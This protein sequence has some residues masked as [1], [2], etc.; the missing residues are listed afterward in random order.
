MK[1][2]SKLLVG[3]L[4]IAMLSTVLADAH[5]NKKVTRNKEENEQNE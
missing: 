4:I 3:I 2:I 1:K 5:L